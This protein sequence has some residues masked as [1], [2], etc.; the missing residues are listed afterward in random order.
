MRDVVMVAGKEVSGEVCDRAQPGCAP[1]CTHC[2]DGF[3]PAMDKTGTCIP[4][5]TAC[6]EALATEPIAAGGALTAS[7]TLLLGFLSI[8]L[9]F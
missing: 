1:D 8:K 7:V 3:V 4:K 6:C 5:C 9:S 2:D